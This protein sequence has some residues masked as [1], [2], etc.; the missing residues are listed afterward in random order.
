MNFDAWLAISVAIIAASGGWVAH[1]FGRL[2]RVE[3][4]LSRVESD[5]RRM[6]L[7]LR[8]QIDHAYRNGIQPL[9]I[10]DDFFGEEEK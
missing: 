1:R 6:W 10:P 7:Y 8:A 2:A 4:Q 9:P 5:N 3:A